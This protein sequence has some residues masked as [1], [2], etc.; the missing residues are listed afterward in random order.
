MKTILV[1]SAL[2]LGGLCISYA[3][4]QLFGSSHRKQAEMD[5][6]STSEVGQNRVKEQIW[7]RM[8]KERTSD[9]NKT[10]LGSLFTLPR[11]FYDSSYRQT[12]LHRQWKANSGGVTNKKTPG[13]GAEK[14]AGRD[15]DGMR[16][17]R[18]S[19]IV[20]YFCIF[21]LVLSLIRA[22]LDM[23]SNLKKVEF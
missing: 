16:E 18:A 1:S 8:W 20:T 3:V 15:F 14:G 4:W 2:L 11:K 5:Y 23:N 19:S 7:D 6:L 10:C 13:E 12:L 9:R 22:A 21:V 17:K